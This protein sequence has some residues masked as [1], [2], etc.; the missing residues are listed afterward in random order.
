MMLA[1]RPIICRWPARERNP[2]V[3]VRCLYAA[4]IA[5]CWSSVIMPP[6]NH[7]FLKAQE[8]AWLDHRLLP[9]P[10][11]LVVSLVVFPKSN[12]QCPHQHDAHFCVSTL[13]TGYVFG[14]LDQVGVVRGGVGCQ[15]LW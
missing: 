6:R 2:G 12:L 14:D 1:T 9:N 3:L 10:I 8:R 15:L 4:R 13:D 5:A 11:Q 7:G